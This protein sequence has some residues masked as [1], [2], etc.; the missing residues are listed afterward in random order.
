MEVRV[1]GAGRMVIPA[2]LRRL[3]GLGEQ[4]G[5]VEVEDTADGLSIRPRDVDRPGIRRD[6]HGLLVIDTGRQVSAREV[7]DAIDEDRSRRG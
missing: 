4:G 1:D 6:E 2:R 7:S 5:T 3:L